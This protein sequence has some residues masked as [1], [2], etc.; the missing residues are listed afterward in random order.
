[1]PICECDNC[2]WKGP[3]EALEEISDLWERVDAGYEFPAGQCPECGA[4]CYL[5]DGVTT[6][7]D[8]YKTQ[9]DELLAVCKAMRTRFTEIVNQLDICWRDWPGAYDVDAAIA[10]AEGR[11][12]AQA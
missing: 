6:E 3:Q 11:D 4:C 5:A 10:K 1:M 2:D 8:R 9:R 12:N 7:R